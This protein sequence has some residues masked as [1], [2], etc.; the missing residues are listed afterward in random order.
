MEKTNKRNDIIL[1]AVLLLLTAAGL[2]LFNALKV[3]GDTVVVLIDGNESA[4]YSL[5]VDKEV[6]IETENGKNVLV[7]RDGMAFV[8]DADCPDGI[9]AEH[10]PI[11]K[12]GETIV[13]LPHS[14][15]IKVESKSAEQTLDIII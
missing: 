7:I 11:T 15:V 12:V 9:C 10:R 8:K 4:S 2:L 3:G 13:C 1:I 14:L 6:V 5:S